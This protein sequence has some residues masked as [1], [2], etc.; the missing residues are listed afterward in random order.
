MPAPLAD[1]LASASG[2]DLLRIEP[3]AMAE[4]LRAMGATLDSVLVMGL[5]DRLPAA[6]L[7]GVL[8][9]GDAAH[10]SVG[11]MLGA[12]LAQLTR[13]VEGHERRTLIPPQPG[14]DPSPPDLVSSFSLSVV[15]RFAS[16][17]CETFAFEEGESLLPQPR[18]IVALAGFGKP[19]DMLI[20][21][22]L[23]LCGKLG[24]GRYEGDVVAPHTCQV[25]QH[26]P[27]DPDGS[28]TSVSV[29]DLGAEV[30]YLAAC[31]TASPGSSV[32]RRDLQLLNAAIEAGTSACIA[33]ARSGAAWPND[34]LLVRSLLRSGVTTG[35][36]VSIMNAIHQAKG[37][38][39]AGHALFG[40]PDLQLAEAESPVAC[41]LRWT[42]GGTH[43]GQ[44]PTTVLRTPALVLS[45]AGAP[46]LETNRLQCLRSDGSADMTDAILMERFQWDGE[47]HVLIVFPD[48]LVQ[49]LS[50]VGFRMVADGAVNPSAPDD[51]AHDPFQAMPA[52]NALRLALLSRRR[53]TAG[54]ALMHFMD[55]ST[56][57]ALACSERLGGRVDWSDTALLEKVRSLQVATVTACATAV[58]TQLSQV[59]THWRRFRGQCHDSEPCPNC[60]TGMTDTLTT[61]GMLT[62]L[63]QRITRDCRRCTYTAFVSPELDRQLSLQHR[64]VSRTEEADQV[65]YKCEVVLSHRRGK[66]LALTLAPVVD[67]GIPWSGMTVQAPP[68]SRVLLAHAS[69]VWPVTLSVPRDQP[70]GLLYMGL[71]FLGNLDFGAVRVPLIHQ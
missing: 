60:G 57:A 56:H 45:L 26:C 51:D 54:A 37:A 31:S 30:L 68:E 69:A 28:K 40:D 52:L 50:A 70:G 16:D 12:D 35:E 38:S 53:E 24:N 15:D 66:G 55:A 63:R 27:A 10:V 4:H 59:L 61:D 18:T 47:P 20:G 34:P 32:F 17:G 13:L 42:D 62:A 8:S 19:I 25:C 71:F 7:Q 14:S 67:A 64:W 39:E 6:L 43:D 46:S 3:E 41:W 1:R 33:I 22:M 5:Q 11:L 23:K 29:S 58:P 49:T 48:R 21:P 44:G 65:L 36:T 2:R 9:A